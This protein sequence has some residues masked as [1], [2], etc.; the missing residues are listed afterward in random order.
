M[1]FDFGAPK[2]TAGTP[3]VRAPAIIFGAPKS[4]SY[5]NFQ[6]KISKP[7]GG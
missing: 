2:F 4:T 7:T 6:L 5:N 1:D 3:L